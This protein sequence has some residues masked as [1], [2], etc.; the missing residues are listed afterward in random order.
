MHLSMHRRDSH[1][2]CHFYHNQIIKERRCSPPSGVSIAVSS[3]G[4]TFA[5]GRLSDPWGK[6]PP[7]NCGPPKPHGQ[8]A[9]PTAVTSIAVREN[10]VKGG[11]AVAA[12]FSRRVP[13]HPSHT[14]I[15]PT[16]NHI[17]STTMAATSP[18]NPRILICRPHLP[19]SGC[20][21]TGQGLFPP[22]CS[23]RPGDQADL[24]AGSQ[25]P[26]GCQDLGLFGSW[27]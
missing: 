26:G 4:V 13:K 15:C 5:G 27:A 9:S 19:Y 24:R 6:R 7:S 17:I 20:L 14:R 25:A 8:P 22:V 2:R 16:H 12:D 10:L 3:T 23:V 11:K 21:G 1:I 18:L